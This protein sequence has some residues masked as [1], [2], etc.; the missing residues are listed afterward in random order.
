MVIEMAPFTLR[1]GITEHHL[2]QASARLQEDF[3]AGQPGFVRRE[4][5]RG[6]ASG[7]IDLVWWE[8]RDLAEQAMTAAA[9]SPVCHQYFHLM[10]ADHADPGA[11][12]TLHSVR[13]VY[14]A[15]P[16]AV[17]VDTPP[18]IPASAVD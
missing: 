6:P 11:G 18:G 3:L 5:A 15:G 9:A 7:W 16:G 17:T 13:A 1:P 2:L 4:L 10:D 8:H 12:V 14:P